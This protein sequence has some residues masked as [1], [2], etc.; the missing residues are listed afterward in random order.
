VKARVQADLGLRYGHEWRFQYFPTR[1]NL[2]DVRILAPKAGGRARYAFSRGLVI[3]EAAEVLPSLL[4]PYQV[5]IDS[6]T[7]LG[8]N[9]WRGLGL[10]V[11]FQIRYESKPPPDKLPVDTALTIG[12][13]AAF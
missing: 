3:S 10:G 4:S 6:L 8:V 7:K 13:E 5:Y 11:A 2:G 9:L 1:M 12:L